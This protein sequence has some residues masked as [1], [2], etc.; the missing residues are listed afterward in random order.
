MN[1][2]EKLI[3][4]FY[5]AFQN[6]DFKRMQNFYHDGATFSDAVFISL[7]AAQVKAMWEMLVKAGKDLKLEFKNV[8]AAQN[9]G[10]AEWVASYTFSRT[11]RK[12]INR[13]TAE[14]EF[15]DG[16]II[17]HKDHFDFYTWAK[18]ALGF[19]GVLLGWTGF[20]KNRIRKSAK[21]N[22]NNFMLKKA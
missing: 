14:F 8:S 20:I 6:R 16:K 19:A 9:K 22:L 7:N 21:Q 17:A 18:Q 2:K 10:S 3:T 13:T 12:V 4:E 15:K 5:T 11:G 1:D